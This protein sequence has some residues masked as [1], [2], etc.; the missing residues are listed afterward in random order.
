MYALDTTEAR[1]AD[2]TG[3]MI[4]EIGKYK[5]K[6][7]QAEN[8]TAKTGTK[9]ITFRFENE[10]GQKASLSLYTTKDNGEKLM[11]FQSLMAI[12]TCLSL[13]GIKPVPGKVVAWDSE[14]K[15]EVTKDGS[16]FPDLCNK[17][18]GLL[19]ETEDYLTNQGQ[20][21][22]RMVLQGVFQASSELTA[23]E[24]LDK[25]TS[26]EMLPKMVAA[27]RHRPMKGGAKPA[28]HSGGHMPDTGFEGM[29]SDDIPFIHCSMSYD[30]GTSKQR[31]MANTTF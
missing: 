27:L 1:K 20:P 2:S 28:A 26:P 9:G 29:D 30:M 18:I 12:M 25:K 17:P 14:A 8:I 21:R 24:I 22:T 4:R 23:S 3:S 15:A 16:V 7:T 13:R 10:A 6:F 5:G 19:L 11:G 31:R